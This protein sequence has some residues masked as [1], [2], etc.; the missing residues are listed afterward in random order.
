MTRHNLYLMH[1]PPPGVIGEIAALRDVPGVM[2]RPV[3][4]C[5][6]HL[7][8]GAA[9]S[10]DATSQALTAAIVEHLSGWAV[11]TCRLVL[12]TL[13]ATP[14]RALLSASEPLRGFALTQT[15]LAYLLAGALAPF[16][17]DTAQWMR[18][19]K[20]HVTLGYDG[21]WAGAR[22]ILP[23]SWTMD[24][25]CLV[26]SRHGRGHI[27]RQSWPADVSGPAHPAKP[28]EPMSAATVL[29]THMDQQAP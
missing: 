18:R 14:E 19:M 26:E 15:E 20:P 22:P 16:G 12:D 28:S 7:T 17:I 21:L 24:R 29:S 9:G 8:I 6:L 25:V 2:R 13:V 1:Y 11:P 23:I 5:R 27:V 3:A 4:D 10:F